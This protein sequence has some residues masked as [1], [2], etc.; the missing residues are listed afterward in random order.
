MKEHIAVRIP[1]GWNVTFALASMLYQLGKLNG[2]PL[3]PYRFTVGLVAN[4][5]PVDYARNL[6]VKEVLETD[7]SRLWFID[8]DV[9]PSHNCIQILKHDADIV[10]GIYPMWGQMHR[11]KPEPPTPQFAVYDRTSDGFLHQEIREHGVAP[12]GAAGTGMMVIRRKV[13]EDPRMRLDPNFKDL[14]GRPQT[15]ADDAPP[16]L[17]KELH[18]PNGRFEATEDMDFCFRAG[19]LGYTLLADHGVKCDHIKT[20]GIL[21]VVDYAVDC[22]NTGYS[23]HKQYVEDTSGKILVAS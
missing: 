2:E 18:A 7:A 8:S 15:V 17:F 10:A 22:V 12:C 9:I 3:C 14:L 20:I 21:D 5:R 23:L 1:C 16:C 4:V 13:L 11:D 6:I 19:E